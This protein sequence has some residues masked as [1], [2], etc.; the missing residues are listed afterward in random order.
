ME[1]VKIVRELKF[2]RGSFDSALVTLKPLRLGESKTEEIIDTYLK[3]KKDVTRK[4]YE[5]LSKTYLA[6]VIKGKGR[7]TMSFYVINEDEKEK[8]IGKFGVDKTMRKKRQVWVIDGVEVATDEVEG[9]SGVFIEIQ[10]TDF[11][12]LLKYL[13]RL[14]VKEQE[15]ISKPYSRLSDQELENIT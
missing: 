2:H 13:D 5:E 11:E 9:L 8:L 6:E 4:I 7:F 15:L 3:D 12:E 14:G 1:K 10:G